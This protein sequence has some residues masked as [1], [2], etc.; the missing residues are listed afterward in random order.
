[1]TR[2]LLTLLV[3]FV[4]L[5]S[6]PVL[7]EQWKV[8]SQLDEM[9]LVEKKYAY[10]ESSSTPSSETF[11]KRV[12]FLASCGED[13]VPNLQINWQTYIDDDAFITEVKIG[14]DPIVRV[15]AAASTKGTSMFLGSN[16][17]DRVFFSKGDAP[18]KYLGK[19]NTK[20]TVW[21]L[22]T[23]L[24]TAGRVVFRQ[25]DYRGTRYTAVFDFRGFEAVNT[26]V[27]G[28]CL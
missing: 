1:M 23:K 8:L 2:L 27:L 12:S 18:N 9:T 14:T 26:E 28:S 21:D 13:G 19:K 20:A 5:F 16:W 3:S 22:N 25:Q 24:K 4:P 7:A 17:T 10:K 11:G 15:W 6:S